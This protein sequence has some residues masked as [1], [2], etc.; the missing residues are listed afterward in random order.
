HREEQ[1]N[2]HISMVCCN[3]PAVLGDRHLSYACLWVLLWQIH[4][5]GNRLGV[6]HR[7]AAGG[8]PDWTDRDYHLAAPQG[9]RFPDV[10]LCRWLRSWATV[11]ARCRQ[12]WRAASPF[13][14]GSVH[15]LS[16]GPNHNRQASRL[17]PWLRGGVLLRVADDLRSDGPLDRRHQ[18]TWLGRRPGQEPAQLHAGC[19]RRD[20]HVWHCRLGNRDR[21]AWPVPAPL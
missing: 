21:P 13:R 4:V 10:P 20:L 2:W 15:A 16:G 19:L 18:P 7:H 14:R 3:P 5:Q 17:R 11:R 12:G 6:G 9:D 8:G 1:N